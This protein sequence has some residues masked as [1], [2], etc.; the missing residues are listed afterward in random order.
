MYEAHHIVIFDGVC[1]LCNAWVNYIIRHDPEGLFRFVPM[2]SE[3]AQKLIETHYGPGFEFDTVVLVK[4]D[5][6]YERGDAVIEI[7]KELQGC[8]MLFRAFRTLPKPLRDG[9]YKTVAMNRYRLFGRRDR[10]MVPG[11]D[12]H[13]RFIGIQ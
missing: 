9:L 1:N 2:Q 6:Y 11:E 13:N 3:T 4:E 7:L 5:Q 10:C 8:G 12:I